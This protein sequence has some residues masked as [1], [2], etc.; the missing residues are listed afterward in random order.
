MDFIYQV[1]A[2]FGLTINDPKVIAFLATYP[3]LKLDKPSS[4]SQY[5]IGK[6][7]GFDLLFDGGRMPKDRLLNT[8]FLY[9]DNIDQHK[10]FAGKLPLGFKFL[11][12]HAEL[13][14]IKQPDTTWVIGEGRVPSTHSAPDSATWITPEFNVFATYLNDSIKAHLLQIQPYKPLDIENEW[15]PAVTWQKM[16]L[17]NNMFEAIKLY[18]SQYDVGMAEA[19]KAISDFINLIA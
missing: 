6:A 4:G 11:Q 8:L 1:V 3:S 15:K 16:A 14:A 10:G 5:V 12:T 18:R 17:E 13:A 2:L 7:Y 9:A 19:K